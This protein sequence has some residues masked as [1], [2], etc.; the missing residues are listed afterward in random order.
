MD[1][2][3]GPKLDA[4]HQLWLLTA[5]HYFEMAKGWAGMDPIWMVL[6]LIL[7]A[8]CCLLAILLGV[9]ALARIS[10]KG[11]AGRPWA[12]AGMAPR[13]LPLALA[14]A[15]FLASDADSNPLRRQ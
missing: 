1:A 2:E 5:E 10:T 12:W 11:H 3:G 4:D 9:V 14:L 6:H 8:A 15:A 13:C 7:A